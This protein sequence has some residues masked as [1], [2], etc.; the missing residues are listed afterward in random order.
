M[1]IRQIES[2]F[3]Y[4]E[5]ANGLLLSAA[6]ALDPQE[7][8]RDLGSSHRS[9]LG[10]LFHIVYSEWDWVHFWQ[11]KSWDEISREEPPES[12]FPSIALLLP[13]WAEI[14]TIQKAFVGSLSDAAIARQISYH[15][16][17]GE[18]CEFSL[19]E[20][21]QHLLNHSSYHRGQ[22]VTLLRQF[23]KTPPTTD[24]LVFLRERRGS[25]GWVT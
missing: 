10:T 9:V 1:E 19:G 20:T 8:T 2:Q 3:A 14:V 22:V 5:W 4:N 18:L 17:R 21:L 13:Q 25:G 6:S 23:G 15:D 11:G 7:Q 12:D 16:F 24:F